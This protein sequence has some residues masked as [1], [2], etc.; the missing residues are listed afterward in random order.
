MSLINK[1]QNK[2]ANPWGQTPL[3]CPHRAGTGKVWASPCP[4]EPL[5]CPYWPRTGMF[6]GSGGDNKSERKKWWSMEVIMSMCGVPVEVSGCYN[7]IE[8]NWRY[9]WIKLTLKASERDE[10]GTWMSDEKGEC[11]EDNKVYENEERRMQWPWTCLHVRLKAIT[12]FVV[13]PSGSAP[14]STGS[15]QTGNVSPGIV[16]VTA[17]STVATVLTKETAVS[18]CFDSGVGGGGNSNSVSIWFWKYMCVLSCS[19]ILRC[20]KWCAS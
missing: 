1:K 6:N 15:A 10:N 3:P 4:Y 14:V 16:C 11:S 18:W 8:L 17:L 5:P 9:K 2:K 13:Q 7:N 12:F 20:W 19:Q